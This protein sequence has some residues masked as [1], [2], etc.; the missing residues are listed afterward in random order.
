MI[1]INNRKH[2][3]A[4]CCI[5]TLKSYLILG[6]VET[7]QIMQIGALCQ[8][9]RQTEKQTSALVSNFQLWSIALEIENAYCNYSYIQVSQNDDH[10]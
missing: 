10:D 3:A 8:T 6:A 7:V 1:S 9:V 5:K 2:I 4:P